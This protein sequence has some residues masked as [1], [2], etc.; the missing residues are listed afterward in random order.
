MHNA[1]STRETQITHTHTANIYF[2]QHSRNVFQPN[3]VAVAKITTAAPY[4]VL[5]ADRV[6]RAPADR[7]KDAQQ[8]GDLGSRVRVERD[9]AVCVGLG[10][11]DLGAGGRRERVCVWH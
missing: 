6:Y 10:A 9:A 2:Y 8:V 11:F 3:P 4:R 5:G 1:N 7:R